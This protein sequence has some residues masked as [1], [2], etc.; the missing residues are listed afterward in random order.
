MPLRHFSPLYPSPQLSLSLVDSREFAVA[1]LRVVMHVA[2]SLTLAR[3]N[4]NVNYQIGRRVKM[5]ERLLTVPE[6]A[7]Q[8]GLRE[9]TIRRMI[10]E[11]RIDTVRPSRRAVRVPASAVASILKAGFRPAI[12]DG[13][14]PD[15]DVQ[16]ASDDP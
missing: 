4:L 16:G 7:E 8:M 15:A 14:Q 1:M 12:G 11:R 9:S 6:V 2:L 10:L 5:N 3:Q 13:C